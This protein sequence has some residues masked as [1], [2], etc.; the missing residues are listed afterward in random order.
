MAKEPQT[1]SGTTTTSCRR[2]HETM[3][4]CTAH[5]GARGH[6][7]TPADRREAAAA[8]QKERDERTVLG[9]LDLLDE[10]LGFGRG[11]E[12]ERTR[13]KARL[14]KEETAELARRLAE[15]VPQ[16]PRRRHRVAAQA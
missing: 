2:H 14:T 13:L 10:R 15:A 12:R 1:K 11:A 7:L 3:P 4:G 16:S 8:K 9:Q 6:H 5:K